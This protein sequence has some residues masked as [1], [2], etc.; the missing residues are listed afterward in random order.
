MLNMNLLAIS[1]H[2]S[3]VR[4]Q[5]PNLKSQ[6]GRRSC[7]SS[8]YVVSIVWSCWRDS[9]LLDPGVKQANWECLKRWVAACFQ[10]QDFHIIWKAKPQVKHKLKISPLGDLMTTL[11]QFLDQINMMNHSVLAVS[12]VCRQLQGQRSGYYSQAFSQSK[13]GSHER[14]SINFS[15]KQNKTNISSA[16]WLQLRNWTGRARDRSSWF[17]TDE[18]C[19]II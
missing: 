1:P 3:W 6:W 10:P 11:S 12:E 13:E 19:F 8:L 16:A 9:C 5:T 17:E 4:S 2:S 15:R 14:L 7:L 18:G